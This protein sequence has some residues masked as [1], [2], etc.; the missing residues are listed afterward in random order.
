MILVG[1]LLMAPGGPG[2]SPP[3][4][5]PGLE[6]PPADPGA[7]LKPAAPA[8]AG[9]GCGPGVLWRAA[10]VALIGS[11]AACAYRRRRARGRLREARL[12]AEMARLNA[13][14][15]AR[16]A[17]R[18]RAIA[19]ARQA[20]EAA[21][22]AAQ[23]ARRWWAWLAVEATASAEAARPPRRRDHSAGRRACI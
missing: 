16:E 21:A 7:S 19:A 4:G 11:V 9:D 22:Q 23:R 14:Q 3:A 1:G 12:A 5:K 18:R 15:R 6:A 20:R 10:A 2:F 8:A 13:L 17:A